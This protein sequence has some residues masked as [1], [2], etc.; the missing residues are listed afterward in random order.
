M[1]KITTVKNPRFKS[2][3]FALMRHAE[4]DGEVRCHLIR[5]SVEILEQS[6]E[7]LATRLQGRKIKILTSPVRRAVLSAMLASE[8]V[9]DLGFRNVE[10]EKNDWLAASQ[11]GISDDGIQ[12]ELFE[13]PD[14]FLLMVS[15]E[16]DMRRF[17]GLEADAD[18][19]TVQNCSIFAKEFEIHPE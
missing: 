3:D 15:H 9:E 1:P 19:G 7:I 16:P 13:N 8:R 17:L 6:I 18:D 12:L 11:F 14:D 5:E 10:F 2:P 4:D